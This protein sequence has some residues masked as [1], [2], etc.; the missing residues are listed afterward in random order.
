MALDQT[1]TIKYEVLHAK[2]KQTKTGDHMHIS[3]F[4][5]HLLRLVTLLMAVSISIV[6]EQ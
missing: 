1:A 2:N 4:K 3:L 5:I 6:M